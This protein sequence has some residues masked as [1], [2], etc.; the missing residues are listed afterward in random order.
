MK[1]GKAIT[2]NLPQ[3]QTLEELLN[4]H[5]QYVPPLVVVSTLFA[6]LQS[7]VPMMPWPTVHE[8]KYLKRLRLV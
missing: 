7:F 5:F 2:I 8:L 3:V 6:C 4:P 1:G